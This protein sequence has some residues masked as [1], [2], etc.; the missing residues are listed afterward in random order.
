MAS[1]Q[2]VLE[3][4]LTKVVI[5]KELAQG[6]FGVVYLAQDCPKK[7]IKEGVIG[8]EGWGVRDR[9]REREGDRVKQ[10]ALKQILCQS[11]EQIKEAH[12]ELRFLQMFAGHNNIIRLIDHSS[13]YV[14]E[15]R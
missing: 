10:Y 3:V 11:K 7:G 8:I 15:S 9:D 13:M 6:G 5:V 2:T 1:Q 14:Y 4:G 12:D